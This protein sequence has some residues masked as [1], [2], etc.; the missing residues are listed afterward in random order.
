MAN[1]YASEVALTPA[2]KKLWEN[3]P[4]DITYPHERVLN[5][6]IE[7]FQQKRIFSVVRNVQAD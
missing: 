7:A 5:E 1:Y 4:M 6:K 3:K 2:T